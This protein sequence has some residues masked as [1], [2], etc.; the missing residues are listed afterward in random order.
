MKEIIWYLINQARRFP[1][2]LFDVIHHPRV[3]IKK[4]PVND[5]HPSSASVFLLLASLGSA[6]ILSVFDLGS[7]AQFVRHVGAFLFLFLFTTFAC[8]FGMVL[9]WR[10]VRS[11]AVTR[12]LLTLY[13]YHAGASNV[14]FTMFLFVLIAL[15]SRV[16][17]FSPDQTILIILDSDTSFAML[18]EPHLSR[19]VIVWSAIV[20]LILGLTWG[21]PAWLAYKDLHSTGWVRSILALVI[22]CIFGLLFSVFVSLAWPLIYTI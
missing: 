1:A 22:F 6:V 5:R 3:F 21:I 18:G 16:S 8:G 2:S 4:L 20:L 7:T 13:L 19:L 12:K 15:I 9:A 17:R 10:I 14:I 11:E